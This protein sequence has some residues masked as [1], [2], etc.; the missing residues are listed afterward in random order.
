[1]HGL[2]QEDPDALA[3]GLQTGRANALLACRTSGGTLF[4]RNVKGDA[5]RGEAWTRL[6]RMRPLQQMLMG[7]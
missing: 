5:L 6:C 4:S 2:S 3:N 7:H 1:M